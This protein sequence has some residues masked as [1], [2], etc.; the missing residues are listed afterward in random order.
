MRIVEVAAFRQSRDIADR[1][2]CEFSPELF[3]FTKMELPFGQVRA[4]RSSL[5]TITS[6]LKKIWSVCETSEQRLDEPAKTSKRKSR[7]RSR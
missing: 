7:K 4:V 2:R 6:E 5:E 3:S 1:Q